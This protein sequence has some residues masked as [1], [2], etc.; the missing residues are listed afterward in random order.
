[1]NDA[2]ELAICA[3]ESA[4]DALDS[5]SDVSALEND[6]EELASDVSALEIVCE[7]LA[8]VSL[9]SVN[10]DELAANDGHSSLLAMQLCEMSM[11]RLDVSVVSDFDA[12]AVAFLHSD[13]VTFVSVEEANDFDL[14]HRVEDFSNSVQLDRCETSCDL[15]LSTAVD[16]L[17]L[18]TFDAYRFS[19]GND[20]DVN[21]DF[22]M[23][24]LCDA[25]RCHSLL[26]C[27]YRS[28]WSFYN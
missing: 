5:V 12:A 17:C 25:S 23:R 8:N 6:V 2:L 11:T 26:I 21:Y 27:P 9:V 3:L 7:E 22:R 4:N 1:M 24:A 28:S 16:A 18:A 14:I 10:G 13:C 19:R 20:S 15:D